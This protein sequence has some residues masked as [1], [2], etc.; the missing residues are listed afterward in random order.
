MAVTTAQVRRETAATPFPMSA[1]AATL[2]QELVQMAKTLAD[3]EHQAL[4]EDIDQLLAFPNALDSLGVVGI[5][6]VL[7]EILPFE[8]GENVVRAGGYESIRDALDHVVPGIEREWK[9]HHNGG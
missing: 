5:L 1:V 2:Q 6:C 3:I 7:D 9:K 4:P 8:V